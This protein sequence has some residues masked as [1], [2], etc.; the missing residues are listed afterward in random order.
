MQSFI[1]ENKYGEQLQLAGNSD[2]DVLSVEGLTP[3]AAT[4]NM[5]II[6]TM[7]GSKFNSSRTNERNIVLTVQPRQNVEKNRINLYKFVKVKQ[8]VKV[9]Y[10]NATRDVY[11]EGYVES[12]TG[13][14]F[15]NDE[16]FQISIICAQPYFIDI[17]TIITQ[18]SSITAAFEFPFS[19]D[20]AG[21]ELGIIAVGEQTLITNTGDEETGTLIT[22]YANDKVLEPT[23]YNFDTG[24]FF[25]VEIELNKGD[26]VEIN[27]NRG[28][29]SIILIS[30]GVTTNILNKIEK[31]STWFTLR[32]GD[33]VFLFDCIY[34][35]ENLDVKFITSPLYE[36]V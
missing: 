35:A 23:I 21:V 10:T 1:I 20:E 7:D 29:K 33:N 22:M 2:Y 27:T 25:T 6:A 13:N 9:Y 32:S 36:G 28:R 26:R 17:D 8:Y 34:G 4:I 5:S 30:N 16:K 19:I 24:E 14:L 11:I 31:G 3:P 15:E 12:F 18:F